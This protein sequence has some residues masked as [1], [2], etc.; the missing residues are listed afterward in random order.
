MPANPNH[1]KAAR[2][3]AK[4]A[5]VNVDEATDAV[6]D[7]SVGGKG[8]AKPIAELSRREREAVQAQQGQ[9]EISE[10]ARGWKDGRG[11]GRHG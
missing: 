7:L 11:Q 9:G 2:N 5:P 4:A 1:S 10:A 8:K 3:Q 6:K